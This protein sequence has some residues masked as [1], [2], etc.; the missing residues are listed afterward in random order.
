M[1]IGFHRKL[2]N[3][4]DFYQSITEMKQNGFVTKIPDLNKGE[5]IHIQ[6]LTAYD[7]KDEQ[8]VNTWLAVDEFKR[9]LEKTGLAYGDNNYAL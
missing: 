4:V 3:K 7:K 2:K 1:T 6:Y 8:K 9:K 5:K